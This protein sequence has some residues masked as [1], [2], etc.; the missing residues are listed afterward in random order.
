MPRPL[1]DSVKNGRSFAA[2]ERQFCRGRTRTPSAANLPRDSVYLDIS[3]FKS[4]ISFRAEGH[5]HRSDGRAV[6]G[7]EATA[8]LPRPRAGPGGRRCRCL[9]Q[10]AFP[11]A[12]IIDAL[13]TFFR[14]IWYNN[15]VDFQV[16]SLVRRWQA[17]KQPSTKP[18]ARIAS[19][20]GSWWDDREPPSKGLLD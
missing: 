17:Q 1:L 3:N 5:R 6:E 13:K 10:P 2:S 11:L 16:T 14:L 7:S 12:F 19:A 15:D 9:R 18:I 8:K 4:Q 20:K